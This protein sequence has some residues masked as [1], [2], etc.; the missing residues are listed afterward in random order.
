[1]PLSAREHSNGCKRSLSWKWGQGHQSSGLTRAGGMRNLGGGGVLLGGA[2][3]LS[4]FQGDSI[5]AG[6]CQMDSLHWKPASQVSPPERVA[7]T[8]LEI[9]KGLTEGQDQEMRRPRSFCDPH[10]DAV[11][12][13]HMMSSVT[14]R[15]TGRIPSYGLEVWEASSDCLRSVFG[16][17][18][19]EGQSW[20]LPGGL[21]H[22]VV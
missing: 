10:R 6:V 13:K 11:K 9:L 3:S 4:F 20:A 12:V 22:Q 16:L 17:S 5:W 21:P 1:M 18:E 14:P 2:C 15:L 7:W 8:S 19:K